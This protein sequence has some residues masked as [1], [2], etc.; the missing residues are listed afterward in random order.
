MK[1]HILLSCLLSTAILTG[2]QSGQA[3]NTATIQQIQRNGTTEQQIRATF[4][5]PVAM[6]TNLQRGIRTL[7]Y[8]YNQSDEIKRPII[9]LLGTVAGAALGHQVG[10]GSGQAV[11]TMIGGAA[12]GAVASNAVVTRHNQRTLEVDISLH[13]GLVQDY[14]YTEDAYR[15]QPWRPS[16]GPAPL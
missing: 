6:H 12:G 8:Q 11:A 14:R 3:L 1:H 13:N 2:C 16:A 4:G 10:G 5:E 9:G 15:S 7:V